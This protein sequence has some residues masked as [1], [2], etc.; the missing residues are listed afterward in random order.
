VETTKT[1]RR[2]WGPA[3][4]RRAPLLSLVAVGLLFA[5]VPPLLP[6]WILFQVTVAL[7]KAMVV[8]GV[9]LLLMGGLVSFG[10]GMYYA[11][12][13]YAAAFSVRYLDIREAV[14][15]TLLGTLA[16][17]LLAGMFGLPLSRYRGIF[18]AMLNLGL[19]M[20]LYALLVKFYWVTGGTD[21]LRLGTPT[22][23][24]VKPSV[25]ILRTVQY[26]YT[27]AFCALALYLTYRFARSPLG[28]TMRALRDNEVRVEYMGASVRR[29]I[30]W[31]YVTAGA[32]GG[33]GGALTA[34]VI[35]HI[36]PEY[37]YWT[38]SGEFVFVAL[39]G[40]TGSVLAPVPGSL[41]FEFVRNYAYKYSPYTWQMTL[42]FVL[43]FVMLF[44]PGGLWSLAQILRTRW[45]R[46]QWSWKRET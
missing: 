17:A 14:V 15:L 31:A 13:A 37:S 28:Y 12:G 41:V 3:L 38:T 5:V 26:Y 19:S 36:V 34:L 45:E 8:V 22:L 46:W 20:V 35:Q 40:G 29:T 18:F 43:L 6:G 44:L 21:G 23:L 32:L 1:P 16:G 10:Q 9:V 42:G 27:L 7:A 25:A 39:L 11:A 24:G 33:L 30:F 2:E 4:A